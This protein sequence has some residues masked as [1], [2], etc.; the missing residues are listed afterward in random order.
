MNYTTFEELHNVIKSILDDNYSIAAA[1]IVYLEELTGNSYVIYMSQFRDILTH[2]SHIYELDNLFDDQ[3]K[4][5]VLA[6]LERLKGHLERIVIDSYQKICACHLKTIE[7]SVQP[8]EWPAIKTQIAQQIRDLRISKVD[9]TSLSFSEKKQ[10]FQKLIKY[11]E[12]IIN[13]FEL[14]FTD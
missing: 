6:Q 2:L 11:M 5:S 13:K 12:S 8:R 9:I 1:N 14:T 7:E 4:T 3:I 10:N